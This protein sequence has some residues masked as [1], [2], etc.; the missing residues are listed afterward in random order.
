MGY[1]TFLQSTFG[2]LKSHYFP[3]GFSQVINAWQ[4]LLVKAPVWYHIFCFLAMSQAELIYAT[5][6]RSEFRVSYLVL[7][8]VPHLLLTDRKLFRFVQSNIG[9]WWYSAPPQGINS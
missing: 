9:Q 7:L 4:N 1:L 8:E 5:R 6:I 3:A 2:V